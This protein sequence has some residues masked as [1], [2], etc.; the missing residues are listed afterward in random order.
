MSNAIL[1]NGSFGSGLLGFGLFGSK[2]KQHDAPAAPEWWSDPYVGK[3]EEGLFNFGSDVLKG[4]LPASYQNLLQ[5]DSPQFESVLHNSNRDIS[6]AGLNTA[7]LQGNARSGAANAGIT[8]AVADNTSNMRYSDYLNTVTNQKALLGMGLDAENAAGQ[9]GLTNQG[10]RNNFNL[11]IYGDQLNYDS[12]MTQL[13]QQGQGATGAGIG[14]AFSAAMKSLPFILSMV[15]PAAGAAAGMAGGMM[16]GG[17]QGNGV[18][19]MFGNGDDWA[20]HQ[21]WS[22]TTP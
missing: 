15:N 3:S 9:I 20:N 13:S 21:N 4:I 18:L 19:G 2:D 11:G 22:N 16:G 1:G 14:G 12:R 8:K 17:G 6:A 10:Q 7:A 5:F